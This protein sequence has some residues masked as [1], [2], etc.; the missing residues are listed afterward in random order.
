MSN[1]WIHLK[2]NQ[3]EYQLKETDKKL[4]AINAIDCGWVE[5]MRTFIKQFS[6]EGELVLCQKN[7]RLIKRHIEI[8]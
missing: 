5:Q 2:E 3:T 8:I 1:S 4:D 6:Q 7:T